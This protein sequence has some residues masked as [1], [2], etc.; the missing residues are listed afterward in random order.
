MGIY[1]ALANKTKKQRFEPCNVKQGGFEHESLT[2]VRLL[3]SFWCG[4]DVEMTNDTGGSETYDDALGWPNV[5]AGCGRDDCRTC[6]SYA[7]QRRRLEQPW[8]Y[9]EWHSGIKRMVPR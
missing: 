8:T 5:Y 6:E 3:C 4:D 7:E 9:G 1:W 2:V